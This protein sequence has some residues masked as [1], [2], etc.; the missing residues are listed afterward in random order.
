MKSLDQIT[1]QE[2]VSGMGIAIDQLGIDLVFGNDEEAKQELI[3]LSERDMSVE[4]KDPLGNVIKIDSKNKKDEY[5]RIMGKHADSINKE[6]LILY[7]LFSVKRYTE[8]KDLS[9]EERKSYETSM[10]K[11]IELLGKRDF[12][13][14]YLQEVKDKDGKVKDV[15]RVI[16][17]QEL[18]ECVR[19]NRP[20]STLFTPSKKKLNKLKEVNEILGLDALAHIL[21]FND[22]KSIVTYGDKVAEYINRLIHT[23]LLTRQR[24]KEQK[25]GEKAILEIGDMGE[26]TADVLISN[27]KYISIDKLYLL[28]SYRLIEMLDEDKDINPK[29]YYPV[30]TMLTGYIEK[31]TTVEIR[32]KEKSMEDVYSND[33]NNVIRKYSL[34]DLAEDMKRFVGD[35]FITKSEIE[36]TKKDILEGRKTL[37]TADP[38]IMGFLKFDTD[39]IETVAQAS[40]ENILFTLERGLMDRDAI[41][42]VLSV[43]KQCSDKF[44]SLMIEKGFIDGK[45]LL[46]LYRERIVTIENMTAILGLDEYGNKKEST[47]I[48]TIDPSFVDIEYIY[49]EIKEHCKKSRKEDK[50]LHELYESYRFIDIYRLLYLSGE[51]TEEELKE[52]SFKLIESF[53]DDLDGKVLETLYQLRLIRL[54]DAAE[55]GVNIRNL[56]VRGEIRPIDVKNLYYSHKIKIDEIKDILRDENMPFE[57]KFDLICSTFDGET[58]EEQSIREELMQLLKLEGKENSG[59]GSSTPRAKGETDKD[60]GPIRKEFVSDPHTRWKLI[61]LLDKNY[62][63]GDL[64]DILR[65]TDGHRIFFLPKFDSV[66]IEKMLETRKGMLVSSYAKA[67]YIFSKDVFSKFAVAMIEDGK[68]DR[69]ILSKM[70]EHGYAT[71]I[72]HNRRWGEKLKEYFGISVENGYSKEEVEEIDRAIANVEKSKQER[73]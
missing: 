47:D 34:N 45:D 64:I 62:S 48:K 65:I 61:S 35:R 10:R 9:K 6:N 15:V 70:E 58:E 66:I 12:N 52:A 46:A 29:I 63:K 59:K 44:L 25:D 19:K 27:C 73:E 1:V 37:K 4:T 2:I 41:A 8:K 28:L 55:W 14:V 57:E 18:I 36:E 5:A 32:E 30:I 40:E 26:V 51:K 20:L 60:P 17:S 24:E 67:T 56:L 11:Y 22:I 7:S 38:A 50:D 31:G 43:R 71:K 42:Y 69:T 53:G 49:E 33:N 13:I 21:P 68:V 54:E 23:E 39:E 16:N 72:V 3:E